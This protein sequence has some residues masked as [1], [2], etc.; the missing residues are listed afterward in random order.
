MG[1]GLMAKSRQYHF[2]EDPGHGWLRVPIKD[3][4]Q[5]GLKN[6]ISRFSY[7]NGRNVFLE[8][9]SD[10]GKFIEE[11]KAR[12]VT[13]LPFIEHITDNDSR[14]RS[15]QPYDPSLITEYKIRQKRWKCESCGASNAFGAM[16]CEN[17]GKKG[18]EDYEIDERNL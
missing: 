15:F 12:S 2:F 14:I 8:E 13:I 10:A 6:E 11:L 1:V 16:F 3:I 7:I 17:C 18:K 4:I 5:L 9:D